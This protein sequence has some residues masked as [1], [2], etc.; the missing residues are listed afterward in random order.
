[1][2]NNLDTLAVT[3]D[4]ILNNRWYY[5]SKNAQAELSAWLAEQKF[6]HFVTVTY[7]KEVRFKKRIKND[8]LHLHNVVHQRAFG[9]NAKSRK[10]GNRMLWICVMEMNNT[11]DGYHVHF[12]IMSTEDSPKHSFRGMDVEIREAWCKKLQGTDATQVNI[13]DLYFSPRVV[14][15]ILKTRIYDHLFF[16]PEY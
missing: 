9:S 15:Y 5:T 4:D 7:G 13:Q 8:L 11:R 16:I 3:I 2:N 10:T 14:D 12:L 1:M 6:S